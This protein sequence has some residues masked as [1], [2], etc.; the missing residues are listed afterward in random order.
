M[1][2]IPVY[3]DQPIRT[4]DQGDVRGILERVWTNVD[5]SGGAAIWTVPGFADT[6]FVYRILDVHYYFANGPAVSF[7]GVILQDTRYGVYSLLANPG[8]VFNSRRVFAANEN[9]VGDF[10]NGGPG[11]TTGALVNDDYYQDHVPGFW[12]DSWL[13]PYLHLGEGLGG[14]VSVLYEKVRI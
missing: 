14:W 10:T 12:F 6:G 8:Q 3:F 11:A 5:T 2:K 13:R 7:I 4:T 9:P 1:V